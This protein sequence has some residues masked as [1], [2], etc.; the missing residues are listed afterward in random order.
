MS[1][2]RYRNAPF[3][4][5]PDGLAKLHP[6][7]HVGPDGQV[8]TLE[9]DG[10]CP[11]CKHPVHYYLNQQAFGLVATDGGG[12]KAV[13]AD[14]KEILL[15]LPLPVPA[16]PQA[17]AGLSC[18][19]A[20]HCDCA[21][22]H[23]NG[24]DGCG[25]W[26]SLEATWRADGTQPQLTAGPALSLLEEHAAEARDALAGSELGRVQAAAANW[27]T[28]LGALFA[29]IPTLVVVKGT[30]T[31]DK[32]SSGDKTVVGVLI[33]VGTLLAVTATLLALRA[34]YGPLR[35]TPTLGDDLTAARESEVDRTLSD[36]R[37]TR[38]L[39]VLGVAAL[40][41]SIAYAWAA[42]QAKPGLSVNLANGKAYCGKLI[43]VNAGVM[44]IETAD[45][46]TRPIPTADITSATSVDSC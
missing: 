6:H 18:T 32:L 2:L 37:L 4:L 31:V 26:L 24:K 11:R 41:A 12:A 25:A 35:R 17:P 19:F 16:E 33:A 7:T 30:D 8:E 23:S 46:V 39:S 3:R 34:A 44:Q 10:F 43:G 5:T 22:I 28:G 14:Q 1:T 29:L 15:S 9:I 45:G 27:K 36:L 38:K 13:P 21:E 42:P 20:L 40:A